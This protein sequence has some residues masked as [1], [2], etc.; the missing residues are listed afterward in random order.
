MPADYE[1]VGGD[2]WGYLKRLSDGVHVAAGLKSVVRLTAAQ[3]MEGL[4]GTVTVSGLD[5]E[6]PPPP[7]PPPKKTRKK[8]SAAEVRPAS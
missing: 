4:D 6:E 8:K 1:W 3:I 5:A 7:P 2:H